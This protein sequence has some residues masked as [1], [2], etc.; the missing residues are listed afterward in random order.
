VKFETPLLEGVLLKRYKRFLA[1][2][3]LND[4][5]EIV[6]VHVP[7]PG[8]MLGVKDPGSPCRI[9]V[10]SNLKRKIPYTLEM[11]Q[12][13]EGS[14]VGVN[15]S[16]TNKLVAEAFEQKIV[17]P[18]GKFTEITREVKVGE[19]SRLDIVLNNKKEKCFVEVK[20]VSMAYPPCAVFPD[21]VTERGQKHLRE[22]EL[23]ADQGHRAEI[24]F[25]VQREDC[26][27]FRPCDEIDP[28]Y[29]K[30]L[31]EV[32]KKGVEVQCWTCKVTPEGIWLSHSLPVDLN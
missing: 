23:L 30:L 14:W 9:S 6:L 22:L 29:G 16:I 2:V 4:T 32:S 7:N 10:S 15:T 8:S 5:G 20:N 13:K 21:A 18:W 1:D 11:V 17:K 27:T 25:V 24:F 19:H 31:R 26:K 28:T 12:T 3:K